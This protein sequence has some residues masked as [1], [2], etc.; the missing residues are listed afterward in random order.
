[1][2]WPDDRPGRSI[3]EAIVP[4]EER[5]GAPKLIVVVV[6]DGGGTN[7][8]RRWRGRWPNVQALM[9]D[10][11]TVMDAIVGSS[12]S[13]TPAAHTNLGTGV[14]PNQHGIVDLKIRNGDKVVDPFDEKSPQYLQTTTIGDL[15]D[16]HTDNAAEVG[17][18]G[19]SPWHLGMLGYG[20][21]SAGGDKDV[22]AIVHNSGE[23]IVGS[24][25]YEFPGY[26]DGYPG[27]EADIRTVDLEDGELDQLWLGNDVFGNAFDLKHSPAFILYQ[28]R[29]VK[30]MLDREGF[31]D[32]DV[33]DLFFVNY[34]PLDTIGHKYNMVADEIGSAVEY[35]DAELGELPDLSRQN[36]RPR[37]VGHGHDC[38]SRQTPAA[39]TNACVPDQHGRDLGGCRRALRNDRRRDVP[40]RPR[41]ALLAGPRCAEDPRRS[42]SRTSPTTSWATR[43]PTTLAAR[44]PRN[45]AIEPASASSP[46][47]GRR[48]APTRS[49]VRQSEVTRA[50]LCDS[51][52]TTT[53][54]AEAVTA[55]AAGGGDPMGFGGPVHVRMSCP[56]EMSFVRM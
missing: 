29:L 17:M 20:S 54:T 52:C 23:N 50:V 18:F 4:A 3:T 30:A 46:P 43:S 56:R 16:L 12:P 8:L 7:V 37:R 24:K 2:P 36:G 49:G 27:L 6:W 10:G 41:R 53:S 33:T 28:T 19:Y 34:K 47:P 13:N 22:M 32:D 39:A 26:V 35:S 45:T 25:Y 40:G 42:P 11:T 48:L 5:S 15:W 38:R 44:S 14:F 55:A 9:R 51:P 1:M 21:Y 31:G